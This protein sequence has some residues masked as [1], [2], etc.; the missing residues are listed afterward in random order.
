[1]T[2]APLLELR[3]LH[4]GY[5]GVTVVHGVDLAVQPGEVVAL[6]G[7]NGAGKTTTLATISGL[8]PSL[9]GEVLV[10]GEA[11]PRADRVSARRARRL[12]RRGLAHVPEDRALF[13]SLSGRQHLRL[14]APRGDREAVADALAPFPVLA[15]IIDRRAG[16]LSG[17]EQ[18]M[19]AIAR[20]LAA[21]PRLLMIDELSLGLAPI[22]VQ[23]LLPLVRDIA[24]TTG[25]GVLLVEQ[26]V[27]AALAIADRAY[28]L[29]R[30]RIALQGPAAELAA[31]FERITASYLTG[32]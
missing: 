4:A 26:H 3:A 22:I 24:Q 16:L 21:R 31:D 25:I 28:V 20:A 5:L 8:L 32:G 19:L 29:V 14:A 13:F 6:L 18:Q 17:G 15:D 10:L 27:G 11:Q 1:V 2:G 30:G 9:G 12:A 7:P 23:N